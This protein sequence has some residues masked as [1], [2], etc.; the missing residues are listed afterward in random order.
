MYTMN[1]LVKSL[2]IG[3]A[4]TLG[5][6]TQAVAQ[7][8]VVI[9]HFGDPLPYKAL[10]ADGSLEKATG[11]K[12]EWRQFASGAEV[13]AAMASGGIQ[14]SEIGS[15][16]LSAG[17]SSGL[18]YQ[19]V[20]A[21]KVIDSSEALVARN[22]S[23]IDKPADLKGK[24]IAVPIG[25]TAHYSLMGALKMNGLTEK[26]VTLLGMSPA[27]I[28]A[29]WSQNAVDAAFVWVPVQ[30]KLRENGKV[31]YTAGDVARAAGFHTFNAWVANNKFAAE[32]RD[33]LVKFLRSMFEINADYHKN[34]AAWTA[35]SPKVKAVA[36]SVGVSP[37]AVVPM[38]EGT[39]YPDA[40]LTMSANWMGGGAAKTIKGTAEFLKSAGRI[41]KTADDYG[42]FVNA[43]F[44]KAAAGK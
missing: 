44:A 16:P 41:N 33:G 15:S 32:N 8:K 38:L 7:T 24:R 10:I 31:L 18:P 20:S 9:G 12:I 5:L 40:D 23:G 19:M 3:T 6:V 14:I 42:Q 27:E 30:A 39:I 37:A 17:L 2:V 28:A 1:R 29:A 25:S 26:D 4:F 22:G 36:A 34:K 21:G 35:D 13:N 43:E 11:W